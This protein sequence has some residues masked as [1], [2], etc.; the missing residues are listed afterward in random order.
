LINQSTPR[1]EI[2]FPSLDEGITGFG[3]LLD[4]PKGMFETDDNGCI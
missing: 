1:L 2:T 4:N 3:A